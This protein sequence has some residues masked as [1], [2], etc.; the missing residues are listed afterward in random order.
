V[1]P[2]IRGILDISLINFVFMELE[3]NCML[4]RTIAPKTP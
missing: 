1:D 4:N 3:L 2:F